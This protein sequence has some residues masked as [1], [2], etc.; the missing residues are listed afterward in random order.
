MKIGLIGLGKMGFG[1]AKH[2]TEDGFDVVATD[3]KKEVVDDAKSNG[4]DAVYTMGEMIE[5]LGAQKIVLLMVPAS[6]VGNCIDNLIS[7]MS[8]GDIIADCGNSFYKDSIQ[9]AQLLKENGIYFLDIGMSGGIRIKDGQA[10]MMVGGDINAY[11]T[12]EP[13][14]KSLCVSNGYGHVGKSGAGH[15]VK[16]YHNLVEYITLEGISEGAAAIKSISEREGLGINLRDVFDLWNH[17]SI[18]EGK[19]VE[20]AKEALEKYGTELSGVNGHVK[21]ETIDEMQKL[22]SLSE[23][24]GVEVPAAVVAINKR[25]ES[26]KKGSYATKLINAM[27]NVFGGHIPGKNTRK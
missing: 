12:L 15:L 7:K 24:N 17:G 23:K 18:N 2:L 1:A 9:R 22:V 26:N 4:I 10:C 21:G 25:I 14:F 5:K 6:A 11:D 20:Y 27:R 13:V 19:L 8:S 16:G 3:V